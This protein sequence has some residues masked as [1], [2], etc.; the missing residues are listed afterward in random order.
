MDYEVVWTESA[1]ASLVDAIEYIARDSP[2]YAATFAVRAERTAASL[3]S[4][5]ERGRRVAEFN[6]PAVR[7]LPVVS[8]RL[9]YRVGAR[10]VLLLVFIHKSRD[11]TTLADDIA[12]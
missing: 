10:R 9:I 6:D 7:E 4:F 2:S 12:Q 5:P 11:V 1:L 8:H 3:Q